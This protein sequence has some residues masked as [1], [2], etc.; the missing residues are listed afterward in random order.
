MMLLAIADDELHQKLRIESL[1][2]R[3]NILRAIIQLKA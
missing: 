2:K 3:K 1:G